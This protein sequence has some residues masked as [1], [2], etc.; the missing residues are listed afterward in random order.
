MNK[1]MQ[2]TINREFGSGGRFIG[3]ALANRLGAKLVDK[4]ILE[5]AAKSMKLSESYLQQFDEKA[6]SVWDNFNFSSANFHGMSIP[7]QFMKITNNELYIEQASLMRQFAQQ[8]TCVFLGRCA[9]YILQDHNPCVR[10]FLYAAMPTR[11]QTI[12]EQYGFK[13]EKHMEKEVAK[14]DKQRAEYYRTYTGEKW[15]AM[16][17]YDLCIDTTLL[18]VEDVVEVIYSYIQKYK[19]AKAE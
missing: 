12:T 19:W 15:Q 10:I 17:Q 16:H 11:I 7:N 13:E 3:E 1:H 5:E 9:N 2:I 8:E 14:I 6:P 18:S 4:L